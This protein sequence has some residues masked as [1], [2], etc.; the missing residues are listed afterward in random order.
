MG[1]QGRVGSSL[2]AG[3]TAVY[4]LVRTSFEE[5]VSQRPSIEQLL[6]E[7]IG[8]SLFDTQPEAVLENTHS[9]RFDRQVSFPQT[10]PRQE[11]K[12]RWYRQSPCWQQ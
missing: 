1:A 8:S 11:N 12:T 7:T 10:R 2:T 9:Y 5:E 6:L 3:G 4:A